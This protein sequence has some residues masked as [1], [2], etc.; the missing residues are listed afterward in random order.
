[1]IEY[2]KELLP[3]V[4]FSKELFEK[5]LHKCIAWVEHDELEELHVWCKEKFNSI[6]PEVIANAFN[7]IAA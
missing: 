4:A 3:K 5:E 6:Y 7:N 2:A 1:M